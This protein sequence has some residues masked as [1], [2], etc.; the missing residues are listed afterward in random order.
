MPEGYAKFLKEEVIATDPGTRESTPFGDHVSGYGPSAQNTP[1]KASGAENVGSIPANVQPF[2]LSP[3]AESATR[4]IFSIQS[5]RIPVADTPLA[6]RSQGNLPD[7]H[8]DSGRN[9]TD[10]QKYIEQENLDPS[11]FA[12]RA[13]AAYLGPLQRAYDIEYLKLQI[14][15]LVRRRDI[16]GIEYRPRAEIISQNKVEC[17]G[18]P[19]LDG[20]NEDMEK[21]SLERLLKWLEY[22]GEHLADVSPSENQ[23]EQAVGNLLQGFFSSPKLK[24]TA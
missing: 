9:T 1:V 8:D 7:A 23:V 4:H 14:S 22:T 2:D 21:V 5:S 6:E 17:T 19:M 10:A 11:L 15:D 3:E 18:K 16:R 20:D 24:Q 13:L 12:A